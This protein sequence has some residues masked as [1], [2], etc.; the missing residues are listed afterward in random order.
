MSLLSLDSIRHV[1]ARLEETI[2]FGIIERARFKRNEVIYKP[3][4]VGRG[5]KGQSL[6]GFLLRECEK[7]H[8]KVR[9]YTS[10]DEYP[11]FARLPASIL[12]I[13]RLESP[14]RPNA[15]NVNAQV[16]EI[17]ETRMV[18]LVCEP[19][20]DGQWGSSAV[21][22][23][24]LLQAIS[25]RVHYG[26]FVAEAKRRT[27]PKRLAALAAAGD[28]AGILAAVTDVSVETRVVARVRAKAA[29]LAQEFGPRPG[30]YKVKPAIVA[31]IYRRWI[32][33]LN[34]EVQVRYLLACHDGDGRG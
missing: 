10:P 28:E 17:Y 23:V 6:V 34:K 33:P 12:P 21:N 19:G 13:V 26:K 4:G 31:E 2:I 30:R 11:F 25:K 20:D 22:D 7:S 14:L 32:I 1:L 5:L 15:I 8:A 9:R 27:Q 3:D 29:T 18:P 24:N 16:R